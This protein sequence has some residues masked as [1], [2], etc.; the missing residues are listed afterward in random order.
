[1]TARD[2]DL[3]AKL[4][5]H[6][7]AARQLANKP[8]P[9]ADFF[10]RGDFE[11]REWRGGARLVAEETSLSEWLRRIAITEGQKLLGRPFPRRKVLESG[12]ATKKKKRR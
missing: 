5:A 3:L 1:M 2:P 8:K 9:V 10:A 4:R 7:D 6:L 11:D 12:S